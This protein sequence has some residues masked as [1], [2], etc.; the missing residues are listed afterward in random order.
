[1]IYRL[2]SSLFY[3]GY[4]PKAPGTFGTIAAFI[5]YCLLPVEFIEHSYF[6]L[7]PVLLII[8]SYWIITKAEEQME[9]DDQ[10]IVLDELIGYFFAVIFL[11]KHLLIAVLAFILFRAFDILKPAPVYELQSLKKGAGVIADDV[12]AGIYANLILQIIYF[13]FLR[14]YIG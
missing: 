3:I 11:P 12:M 14:K 4:V 8:P 2:I 6:W 1:M 7:V 13:L 9:R 10:R 5:L